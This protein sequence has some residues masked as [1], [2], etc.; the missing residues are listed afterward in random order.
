[1]NLII[2]A[3]EA[4]EGKAGSIMIATARE[5]L[6][7]AV[8]SAVRLEIRDT[9]SGMTADTKARIFDPF[10]TTRFVGRGLGL[11]AVQGIV[12]RIGGSIEVESTPG[13]GSRFVVLLPCAIQHRPSASEPQGR[14]GQAVAPRGTVLFIEDEDLLRLAVARLLRKKN[15]NVI[16]AH[17]GASGVECLKSDPASID[18]IL[19]DVTLP[20]MPGREVFDELRRI[21]PDISVI[22]CTAYSQETAVAEFG[23][24]DI[25]YYIR[26]PYQTDTL[27][28]LLEQALGNS[29]GV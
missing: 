4:L 19:L 26:K 5:P 12:C 16:E 18:V 6:D 10:F 20:G 22:L 9:G 23:E 15:F 13:E 17:D 25:R 11:S 29:R 27:V 1:M 7:A 24:R 21:R 8:C 3:S 2:N 28:K 14:G